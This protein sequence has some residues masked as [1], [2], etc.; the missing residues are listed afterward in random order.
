M[1]ATRMPNTRF[2]PQVQAW[3]TAGVRYQMDARHDEAVS[4]YRQVLHVAPDH[5]DALHLLGL[6]EYLRHRPADA[7]KHISAALALAPHNSVM[8]TNLKMVRTALDLR[9]FSDRV[10]DAQRDELPSLDGNGEVH[11]LNDYSNDVGGSEL[12]SIELGLRLRERVDTHFWSIND[13]IAPSFQTHEVQIVRPDRQQFPRTGTLIIGGSYC[14]IGD[15]IGATR[16]RR[17]I[18]IY[19]V[20]DPSQLWRCLDQL[21][22]P[23]FPKI[24]LVYASHM[25]RDNAGLPGVF[26]PS[27]LGE[28]FMA[29][30]PIDYHRAGRFVVGR[31]SRDHAIKFHPESAAFFRALADA[32]MQVRLMGA[33]VLSE[34][35]PQQHARLELLPAGSEPAEVF[36]RSL[37]CFTF[38][39]HAR[40]V[41]PWGRVVTEAMAVGLPVV[42]HASGGYQEF[43]E[44][45]EN[46]ILFHTDQQAYEAI[47]RLRADPALRQR[48]G[49]AGRATIRR[50]FSA[51]QFDAHLDFYC[52]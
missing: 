24:E 9:G 50:M 28:R 32:D 26:G 1:T 51:E 45:G 31:L 27:P 15:W 2:S 37:D 13:G 11:V 49:Q 35:L 22:N 18:V 4:M 52:R 14:P 7:V 36:L 20:C 34:Q 43:V 3:L 48:L 10:F 38:R 8:Q 33:T 29:S 17:I 42:L 12:R 6:I 23:N 19:N 39:T 40:W 25:M 47:Q 44:D 21:R 41:E 5:P 46:G 30:A 16:F